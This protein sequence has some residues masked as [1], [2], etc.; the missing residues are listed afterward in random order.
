MRSIIRWLLV[1][2]RRQK[3]SKVSLPLKHS[4]SVWCGVCVYLVVVALGR[5]AVDL[6]ILHESLGQSD[7]SQ[8]VLDE[9]LDPNFTTRLLPGCHFQKPLDGYHLPE[10]QK[11][12]LNLTRSYT[13][14]ESLENQPTKETPTFKP[15]DCLP[16][17]S[18]QLV[19]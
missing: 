12:Y 14:H 9:A 13:N 17:L 11:L 3:R 10:T 18:F 8:Q 5:A 2:L 7:A 15:V 4:Q 1:V 19:L 16:L 6:V